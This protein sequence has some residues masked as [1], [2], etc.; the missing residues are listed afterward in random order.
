MLVFMH[1]E[2]TPESF[3]VLQKAIYEKQ[4]LFPDYE[5]ERGA[6]V[7]KVEFLSMLGNNYRPQTKTITAVDVGNNEKQKKTVVA[8]IPCGIR[9]KVHVPMEIPF[10]PTLTDE[11]N[12]IDFSRYM[13]REVQAGEQVDLTYAEA[14]YLLSQPYFDNL[15]S[16]IGT[17]PYVVLM[18]RFNKKSDTYRSY[19]KFKGGPGKENIGAMKD[20]MK[21]I[22]G[23]SEDDNR[24]Y[25]YEEFRH[26]FAS[27]GYTSSYQRRIRYRDN[28]FSVLNKDR[29]NPRLLPPKGLGK[30]TQKLT[31]GDNK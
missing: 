23:K 5:G 19:T 2:V 21:L 27:L 6:Y 7:E 11:V 9:V 25:I 17:Q 16:G 10:L 18:V 30:Y 14:T 1:E 20:Y 29:F 28:T 4:V 26:S 13:I 12:S 24:I 8:A 3:L 31:G 22:A 15:F